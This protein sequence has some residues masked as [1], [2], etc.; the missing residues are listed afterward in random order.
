[1]NKENIFMSK[2]FPRGG[3]IN[4]KAFL[5]LKCVFVR[6]TFKACVMIFILSFP[7]CYV[8]LLSDA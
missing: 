1:M 4:I 6:G 5:L 3:R 7:F 2:I 8:L